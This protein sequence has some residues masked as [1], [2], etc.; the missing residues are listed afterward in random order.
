MNMRCEIKY[1][2]L[3]L[4]GATTLG[5]LVVRHISAFLPKKL[6]WAVVGRRGEE[7][8]ELSSLV[9][10]IG[11]CT[12]GMVF[13]S[14]P[15]SLVVFS[16][17]LGVEV[18]EFTKNEITVLT[19]HTKVVIALPTPNASDEVQAWLVEACVKSGTHYIDA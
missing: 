7:E 6:I 13:F 11:D 16:S 4:G 17:E 8:R 2:L 3:V 12:P 19:T 5:G 14:K 15:V 1:D 18:C 9:T 10:K